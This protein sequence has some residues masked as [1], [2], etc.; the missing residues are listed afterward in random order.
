MLASMSSGL[1][2]QIWAKS[3]FRCLSVASLSLSGTVW[4]AWAL[5]SANLAAKFSLELI[6]R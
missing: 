3:R 5:F 6:A 1:L 4:P 2:R